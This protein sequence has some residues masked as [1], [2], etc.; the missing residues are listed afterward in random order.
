MTQAPISGDSGSVL[1]LGLGFIGVLLLALSVAVDA[2]LVFVQRAAVQARADSAVLAGVQAIDMDS[3]YTHGATTATRLVPQAARTRTLEHL[4]NSQNS[5]EIRSLEIVSI[6]ASD[7]T[8][9]TVLRVPVRTAFW[10]IDASM[11][12]KAAARLDYVG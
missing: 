2:S 7:T 4:Q 1:V 11:S 12:V 9:E 8:V 3:Y 5:E 10:P 6:S